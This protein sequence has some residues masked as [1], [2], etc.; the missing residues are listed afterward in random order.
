MED[1]KDANSDH[2]KATENETK[3]AK[4]ELLNATDFGKLIG[5]TLNGVKKM[6]G[7]KMTEGFSYVKDKDGWIIDVE[8][9]KQELRTTV[10][11]STCKS[12]RL[13]Q[14]L[15][16]PKEAVGDMPNEVDEI[17]DMSDTQVRAALLKSEL[18]ISLINEKVLAGTY[19]NK[20]EVEKNL[21]AM[22]MEIRNS[23]TGIPARV[24]P[25]IRAAESDLLAENILHKEIENALIA[26]ANLG[27][28]EL[29]PV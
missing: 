2:Q 22:G 13:L 26:V 14:F 10:K 5:L 20:K 17:S 25:M 1:K 15:D 29:I 27:K 7:T 19:V 9:A 23:F 18:R 3:F 4:E 28:K 8:K 11:L 21:E 6:F 12:E 24:M 16:M